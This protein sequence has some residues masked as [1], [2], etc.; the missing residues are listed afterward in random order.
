MATLVQ[1]L[2]QGT[3]TNLTATHPLDLPVSR[4]FAIRTS[5]HPLK[6]LDK[7]S[8]VASNDKLP[9]NNVLDGSSKSPLPPLLGVPPRPPRPPRPPEK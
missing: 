8:S 3:K 5:L 7:E 9:T 1:F 2:R 6:T 4:S